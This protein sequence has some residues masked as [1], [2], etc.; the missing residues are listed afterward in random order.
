MSSKFKKTSFLL[1]KF[2]FSGYSR[3]A[4]LTP[5]T[6]IEVT[7]ISHIEVSRERATS[8][9]MPGGL[10][11]GSL[12]T[13]SLC[14]LSH[15]KHFKD[16]TPM[17]FHCRVVTVHFLVLDSC[18][19]DSQISESVNQGKI[20]KVKVPLA[21]FIVDNGTSLCCCW[22]DDARAELLLGLQEIAILDASVNLKC[23]KDRNN[24]KIQW[25]LGSC[26]EKMLKKHK[27]VIVKNYGI[28]PDI[29]CRDLELLSDVGNV[30][31]SLEEE[32][33]K[34]IVLN[35]CRNGT[36][37]VIASALDASAI[38]GSNVELPDV[39]PAHNMQ[40]FWVNEIVQVDPLEEARRL[41]ASLEN[42]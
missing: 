10:R 34:F 22:A 38:N 41:Y 8:P 1:S 17:R 33:L 14:L 29:S 19:N 12:S 7:S 24:A 30:L 42:R 2:L 40:N 5:V 13:V 16:C 35:A 11:D 3:E 25:T 26:L 18:L 32:L 28:P 9:L 23:S 36:L 39:Y 37:N 27:K 21:G 6:Y 15:Q 20:P 4:L 31:S